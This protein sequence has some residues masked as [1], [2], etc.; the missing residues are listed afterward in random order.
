[1][2]KISEVMST[3]LITL[4]VTESVAKAREL[5]NEKHIRHLLIVDDKGTLVGLVSERDMLRSGISTLEEEHD[6]KREQIEPSLNV[7]E[8]MTVNIKSM[9]PTDS[10]RAAGL[11]LQKNR[12]G[13]LPVVAG[14]Q[15]KGIITDS[16][17]VGVAI[18][19]IELQDQLEDDIS[20]DLP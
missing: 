1:M 14:K 16:D 11:E 7:S 2:I 6:V 18:D 17:F 3:E 8:I 9:H 5:M 15:L 4:D 13:C 10:L 12:Y 19:M 20:D